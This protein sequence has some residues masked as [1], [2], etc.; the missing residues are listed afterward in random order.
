MAEPGAPASPATTAASSEHYADS[1][2]HYDTN[3]EHYDTNSEQTDVTALQDLPSVQVV[4][5]SGRAP[6]D[7]ICAAILD[8]CRGRYLAL[9]V[10]AAL[11]NRK[12]DTLRTHYL[13]SL[14]DT[15]RLEMRYPSAPNHPSQAYRTSAAATANAPTA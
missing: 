12:A 11:L 3:S 10:L 2:E 9:P 15:G 6:S 1:S 4:R 8:A 14:L 7:Q 13:R 5:A